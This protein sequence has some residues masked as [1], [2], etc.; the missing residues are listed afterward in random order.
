VLG[1]LCPVHRERTPSFFVYPQEQT[2]YCFGC[3]RGGDVISLVREVEGL[4]FSQAVAFLA[5]LYDLEPP[6][7]LQIVRQP[8]TY[9]P[10]VQAA[11]NNLMGSLGQAAREYLQLRGVTPQQMEQ[12]QLG[13]ARPTASS[14]LAGRICFPLQEGRERFSGIQ[15]RIFANLTGPK[16]VSLP[17]S[18]GVF[19]LGPA[20]DA[21]RQGD[22]IILVEGP[23]DC[24]AMH[25]LGYGSTVALCGSK[26]SGRTLAPLY[27]FL[28]R[29][30]QLVIMLDGDEAGQMGVYEAWHTLPQTN[31]YVATLPAGTDPADCSPDQIR[32]ALQDKVA[33]VQWVLLRS[34]GN[35]SSPD[36]Q[37]RGVRAVEQQLAKITDPLIREVWTRWAASQLP[38]AP[39][40]APQP[41]LQM[42]QLTPELMP[43]E[44]VALRLLRYR[45]GESIGL[46]RPWMLR[47]P[48][49]RALAAHLTQGDPLTP[50]AADLLQR[51]ELVDQDPSEIQLLPVVRQ[52]AW[53]AV[54]IIFTQYTPV[55][56]SVMALQES[57]QRIAKMDT[58][59]IVLMLDTIERTVLPHR[60]DSNCSTLY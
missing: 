36:G 37:V 1:G 60:R 15:G 7:Q 13:W 41:Q 55:D 50:E 52:L 2:W 43:V 28:D 11:H 49:A 10:I 4:S 8:D 18:H 17:G 53:M 5:D 20:W 42:P 12:F 6:S 31:V 22:P 48:V 33:L 9:R 19:G 14:P 26:L 29:G 46:I 51:I 27:R 59:E 45:L 47:A 38:V 54:R 39:R 35:D 16:Y 24:L 30:A 25:R 58:D 57:S 56:G 23:L 44:V 40:V 32:Q 21:I 3:K 34:M